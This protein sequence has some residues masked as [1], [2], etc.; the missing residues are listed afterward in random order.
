MKKKFPFFACQKTVVFNNILIYV[1]KSHMPGIQV[2]NIEHIIYRGH[3][4]SIL[5]KSQA[6][7]ANVELLKIFISILAKD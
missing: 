6:A 1:I 4:I 3:A 5:L 2:Q 7:D